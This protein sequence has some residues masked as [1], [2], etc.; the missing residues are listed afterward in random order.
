M[1]EKQ[2]VVQT[3]INKLASDS[4]LGE[5]VVYLIRSTAVW[6]EGGYDF[7]EA[8]KASGNRHQFIYELAKLLVLP[9]AS[10]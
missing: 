10:E 1:N 2:T 4:P 9:S 6:N 7:T 5:V 8:V 3:A